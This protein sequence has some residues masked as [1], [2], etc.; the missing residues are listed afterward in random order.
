MQIGMPH[1]SRVRTPWTCRGFVLLASCLVPAAA[2]PQWRSHWNTEF[3]AWWDLVEHGELSLRTARDLYLTALA[4]LWAMRSFHAL[5]GLPLGIVAALVAVA[6]ASH[7]F[8]ATRALLGPAQLPVHTLALDGSMD[9]LVAHGFV[10]AFALLVCAMLAAKSAIPAGVRMLA[11]AEVGGALLATT[12]AWVEGGPIVRAWLHVPE[13]RVLA[14]GLGLSVLYVA[15]A[16]AATLLCLHDAARRCPVCLRRLRLPMSVG[17]WASQFDP[18]V[19]ELY[20]GCGHGR[21]AITSCIQGESEEW[22]AFDASWQCLF[23]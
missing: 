14:G 10:V 6:L 4:E 9:R 22:R 5:A 21:L 8:R 18:P 20:C 13:L 3:S 19:T 17:T 1:R 2:R 11:A 7:G 23:R 15:A 16:G 12:F